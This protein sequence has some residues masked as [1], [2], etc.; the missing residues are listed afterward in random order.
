MSLIE[1]VMSNSKSEEELR[2]KFQNL[3]NGYSII[4]KSSP[5][6]TG[7][8]YKDVQSGLGVGDNSDKEFSWSDAEIDRFLPVSLRVTSKSTEKLISK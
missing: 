7:A 3:Q 4:E 6:T 8:D 5:T 1:E 2:L